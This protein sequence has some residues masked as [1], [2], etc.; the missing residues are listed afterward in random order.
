MAD[1][2]D[3][4]RVFAGLADIAIDPGTPVIEAIGSEHRSK[5][6]GRMPKVTVDAANPC[7]RQKPWISCSSPAYEPR[8]IT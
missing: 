2:A 6:T 4:A 5:F 1:T 7:P 3:E 8:R